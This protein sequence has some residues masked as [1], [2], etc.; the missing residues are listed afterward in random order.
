MK[1]SCFLNSA[2]Q[3][4]RNFE[5]PGGSILLAILRQNAGAFPIAL[6]TTKINVNKIDP[7]AA[8]K[9]KA[10]VP[11]PSFLRLFSDP[12]YLQTQA[13][14]GIHGPEDLSGERRCHLFPC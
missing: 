8:P 4:L 5:R 13:I 11:V 7:K 12:P 1:R 3:K 14:Q 9:L 6:L 10:S 2:Y